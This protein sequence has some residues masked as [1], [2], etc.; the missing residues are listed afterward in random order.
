MSSSDNTLTRE[1]LLHQLDTGWNEFQTFLA[2][3]T[4][5]QLTQPTD[6]AGWTAKDH[7]IHL[8]LWEKAA[9]ALLSGKSKREAMDIS[10]EVW[11]QGDDPINAVI[12]Q[13]YH[14]MPLSEVMQTLRQN[15]DQF[16]Q[17][18]HAMT[19]ADL[20][21]PYSHYQSDSSDERPLIMWLPWDSFY[22]YRDHQTWIAAIV[23]KQ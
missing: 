19:E 1:T 17:K 7:I 9:L 23:E 18:L 11:T 20:L 22:H 14:A 16:L 13:R 6:A 12:Q 5:E 21:L 4:P 2:S 10:P 15:H 3:L 8:A